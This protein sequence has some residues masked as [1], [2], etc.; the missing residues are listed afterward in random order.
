MTFPSPG[1][2]ISAPR[3]AGPDRKQHRWDFCAKTRPANAVV[4]WAALTPSLVLFNPGLAL[5]TL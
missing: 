4:R 1:A 2:L 5:P 3:Q